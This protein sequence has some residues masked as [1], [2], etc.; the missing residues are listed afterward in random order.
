[1]KKMAIQVLINLSV[2]S[3][4]FAQSAAKEAAMIINPILPGFNPD[5]SIVRVND[6]Y[7]IANST[8]EWFPGVAI[9]HSK[10]LVN[11][12]LIG[13]GLNSTKY[14]DLLGEPSSGGVWAPCLS[15]SDGLFYLVYS[16][17]KT[18]KGPY[19]DIHNY[20]ITARNI[21]GPWSKPIYLNSSGFDASMFHDDD[22]RKWLLNELHDHRDRE[23]RFAGIIIQEYDPKRKKLV[24]PIR[25]IFK[26]TEL[27]KT[28]GPH[29]YKHNGYYY[30]MTAEGGTGYDHAV[31]LARS[32][33]LF[34]PYE[35]QP[36]NP[37]LTSKDK[38]KLELQ[39][40]GHASLVETQNGQWYIVHLCSRPIMP[41]RRC[42]LGRETAIQKVK[43]DSDGWLRLETGG[44]SPQINV[45]APGL[46]PYPFKPDPLRDNFDS[47]KLNVH[48]NTLR[49]P[50]DES[51]MSLTQRP[52]W[53]R[54]Y[55]RESLGSKFRQSLVARRIT[56]INCTAQTYVEFEPATFQQAAGLVCFY[57]T[58]NY[59]YLKITRDENIG[60]CI[61][62]CYSQN[63]NYK[64]LTSQVFPLTQKGCHLKA[65]IK[66]DKLYF[67]YSPDEKQWHKIDEAFDITTLS[68]EFCKEGHFTGTYV[69]LCA[70]DLAGTR[71]K[72]DFD[73]FEYRTQ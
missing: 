45:P 5:P 6:D 7:Y 34:G 10:D 30:L 44:N 43:W 38:P 55:G 59:Y 26:G 33:N 4:C 27:G 50:P 32:K 24:G 71:T 2:L 48:F 12:E 73:Y 9:H 42:V 51:R 21:K 60:R 57:D 53:L 3:L 28:E 14:I 37:I 49:V 61:T 58:Q 47:E 35:V 54:L 20:V 23:K 31:T 63:D 8:F 11:W 17:V 65:E 16:D 56:S 70:Q 66:H 40:A 41:Q 67:S 1:M 29:I 72:A 36:D 46:P 25:N 19:K 52:G 13:Y 18:M 39:K 62:V 68:D 64:E 22:G 15:Y 69:G